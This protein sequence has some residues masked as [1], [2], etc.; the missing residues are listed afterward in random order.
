MMK[1][2]K[3]TR[4]FQPNDRKAEGWPASAKTIVF[5]LTFLGGAAGGHFAIPHLPEVA[6]A[7]EKF[8]MDSYLFGESCI[9]STVNWYSG[10]N[11]YWVSLIN[12]LVA[13]IPSLI[14]LIRI[15]KSRNQQNDQ[16]FTYLLDQNAK[17]RQKI[18]EHSDRINCAS[19]AGERIRDLEEKVSLL[20]A[21][22]DESAKRYGQSCG[23][24][25]IEYY[26]RNQA[27]NVGN[28]KPPKAKKPTLKK[29][30]DAK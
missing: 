23:D 30:C 16:V 11:R 9:N 6:A 27:D 4:K 13:S 10:L 5:L 7:G 29:K 26:R 3:K 2:G 8:L 1:K 28:V 22:N 21:G 17:L 15:M 25:S 20:C 18:E 24:A 19:G 14:A 12:G